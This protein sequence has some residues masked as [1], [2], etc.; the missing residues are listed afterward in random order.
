MG[1]RSLTQRADLQ[2]LWTERNSWQAQFRDDLG[3]ILR[4]IAGEVVEWYITPPD[5]EC[6][7]PDI[8]VGTETTRG[9]VRLRD[10]GEGR[11]GPGIAIDYHRDVSVRAWL[12]S[13]VPTEVNRLSLGAVSAIIDPDRLQRRE[14]IIGRTWQSYPTEEDSGVPT[15]Y[16]YAWAR[17]PP[18]LESW[19]AYRIGTAVNSGLY[20]NRDVILNKDG[21]T[22][23]IAVPTTELVDAGAVFACGHIPWLGAAIE[24]RGGIVVP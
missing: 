22:A 1:W 10:I 2:G 17:K 23:F 3:R 6:G 18:R 9:A 24:P 16:I 8:E 12:S 21:K 14:R 15:F 19:L 7:G 13:G 4:A 11:I 5:Q 20:A